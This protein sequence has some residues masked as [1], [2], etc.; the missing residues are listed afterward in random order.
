MSYLREGR[1]LVKL[2]RTQHVTN[3]NSELVLT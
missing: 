3:S 2:T 1:K